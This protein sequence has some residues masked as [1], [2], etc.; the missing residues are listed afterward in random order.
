MMG[1]RDKLWTGMNDD[2]IDGRSMKGRTYEGTETH[3][4]H[5]V[6]S[7]ASNAMRDKA[8]IDE[9]EDG[10]ERIPQE[11][12]C[13]YRDVSAT[14]KGKKFKIKDTPG[15]DGVHMPHGIVPP[16]RAVLP[17]D[18]RLRHNAVQR[19]RHHDEHMRLRNDVY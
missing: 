10:V 13:E 17:I 19:I 2:R 12:P 3:V 15:S 7:K 5:R 14:T 4:G 6:D 8:R 16:K 11:V 9:V 1:S 18:G